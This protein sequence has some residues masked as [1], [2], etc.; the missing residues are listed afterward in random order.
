M[1]SRVLDIVWDVEIDV[2]LFKGIRGLVCRGYDMN[3]PFVIIGVARILGR[4]YAIPTS[5]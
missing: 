5:G 3:F 4:Y 1:K 2:V